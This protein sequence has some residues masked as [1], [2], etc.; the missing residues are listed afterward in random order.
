MC[1]VFFVVAEELFLDVL[2]FVIIYRE[3]ENSMCFVFANE[4]IN[5][6]ILEI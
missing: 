5:E 2:R 4:N 6:R 1:V 3:N